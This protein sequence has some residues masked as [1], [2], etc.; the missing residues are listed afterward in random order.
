MF[1][2]WQPFL[3]K[4]DR[5]SSELHKGVA[6]P[7]SLGREAVAEIAFS[8]RQLSTRLKPRIAANLVELLEAQAAISANRIVELLWMPSKWLAVGWHLPAF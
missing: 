8:L 2:Q 1:G 3:Q 6:A 5:F 7:V 4:T